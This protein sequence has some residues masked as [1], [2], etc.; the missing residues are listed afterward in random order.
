MLRI[1]TTLSTTRL[2]I[3]HSNSIAKM[4]QA[5]G[6]RH[7]QL[8]RTDLPNHRAIMFRKLRVAYDYMMEA[9]FKQ[10]R[11]PFDLTPLSSLNPFTHERKCWPCLKQG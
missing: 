10:H 1:Q 11:R 6:R 9:L 8:A 2:T 5:R 3:V 7:V 4:W